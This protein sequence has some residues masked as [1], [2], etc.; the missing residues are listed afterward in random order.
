VD[1]ACNVVRFP[2]CNLYGMYGHMIPV[3]MHLPGP[4]GQ[5]IL[6]TTNRFPST[7]PFVR[8]GQTLSQLQLSGTKDFYMATSPLQPRIPTSQSLS[9]CCSYDVN[10]QTLHF[11][12]PQQV[13]GD[14]GTIF[15][16][17]AL[18]KKA[19]EHLMFSQ[20]SNESAMCTAIAFRASPRQFSLLTK[21]KV[22][23][24]HVY[25]ISGFGSLLCRRH[26]SIS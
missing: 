17:L 6:G 10:A 21:L 4:R 16:T 25:V 14:G 2:G 3:E 23:F 5:S 7:W 1:T 15:L 18:S 8:G 12:H 24:N 13:M 22:Q 9:L 19:R 20:P 11:H 26:S